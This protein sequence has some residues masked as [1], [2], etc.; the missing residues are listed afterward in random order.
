MRN[1]ILEKLILEDVRLGNYC[2]D[3]YENY[4]EELWDLED[5]AHDETSIMEDYYHRKY[6]E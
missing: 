2:S 4:E 6:G 3:E 5:R 1:N